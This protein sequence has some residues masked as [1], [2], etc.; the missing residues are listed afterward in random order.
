MCS[1]EQPKIKQPNS[2]GSP[3]ADCQSNYRSI[4]VIDIRMKKAIAQIE[5]QN[6]NL[7]IRIE[8]SIHCKDKEVFKDQE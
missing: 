6:L 2:T 5:Q 1:I 4:A 8:N 7:Q 3:T